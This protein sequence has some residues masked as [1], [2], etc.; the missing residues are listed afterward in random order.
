MYNKSI[1]SRNEDKKTISK[2]QIEEKSL[3]VNLN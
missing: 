3:L 2:I 1:S